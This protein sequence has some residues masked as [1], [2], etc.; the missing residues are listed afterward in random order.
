[1]AIPL[2]VAFEYKAQARAAGATWNALEKV[3]ECDLALIRGGGYSALRPFLPRM[4][5]RENKPPFIRP[6]MVP[7]SSWG[8]N[9]RAILDVEDWKRVR[10]HAYDAAGR[11]CVVCGGRGS[12][13]PVE[14]DEAWAYDDE[15]NIQTLKGVIALCPPCHLVRHWGQAM[16][17]GRIEIAIEQMMLVN[18]WTRSEAEL[19]GD[20]GM[21]IWHS[22][23]Q[24]QW[25][26]DYSWVTRTHGL[27]I[28]ADAL[29]R[30]EEAN[31]QLVEEARRSIG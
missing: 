1:M 15:T 5:W 30:A 20:E 12:E 7:Q 6:F 10:Q 19:A 3:W 9:L 21:H 2:C 28:S 16:V 17:S 22:R 29:A 13:W 18:E 26:I 23:S 4:Y 11:R 8:K 31:R 25:V 24:R 14:A 27:M